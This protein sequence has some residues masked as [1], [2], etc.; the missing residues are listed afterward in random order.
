M[1]ENPQH[2]GGQDSVYHQEFMS[3][4]YLFKGRVDLKWSNSHVL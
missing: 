2:G 4:F 1:A 3:L